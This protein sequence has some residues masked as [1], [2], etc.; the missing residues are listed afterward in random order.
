MD[1]TSTILWDRKAREG[2]GYT[3]ILRWGDRKGGDSKGEL[4]YARRKV[5]RGRGG[6]LHEVSRR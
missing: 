1:D 3:V 4:V 6:R 2:R 5:T